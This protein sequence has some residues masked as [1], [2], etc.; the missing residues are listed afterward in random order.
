[1]KSPLKA[2]IVDL[3]GVITATAEYHYQAWKRLAQEELIPFSRE[4]NETLLGIS[5]RES[6]FTILGQREVT[7]EEIQE[8]M[9][10]KNRYYVSSIQRMGPEDFLPGAKQMLNSI[11]EEGFLLGLASASKNARM[12]LTK[13]SIHH[14]FHTISDGYSVKRGKPAPD[15]FLH[16]AEKLQVPPYSCAVI[17]DAAAGIEGA[18]TAGMLTIGIGPE[19]RVGRAHYRFQHV[20]HFNL[21]EIL[22][23]GFP[24]A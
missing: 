17:E 16:T 1:M 18:R 19:E 6:L 22:Q 21:Q 10:R 23:G 12:V 15:L 13:L 8:L 2:F 9:E 11:R 24:C 7:E 14:L 3:D 20:A 5:R 4:V